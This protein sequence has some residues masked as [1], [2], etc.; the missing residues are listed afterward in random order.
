MTGP[1][2]ALYTRAGC[3]LCEA[4]IS[5]LRPY[6]ERTGAQLE[7]V[8]VDDDPALVRA[9]GADVPVLLVNDAELCRHRL[10]HDA[11]QAHLNESA[12]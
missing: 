2:L 9:Y 4:M 5:E 11:L 8:D 7:L 3:H 6:L 10:D 12:N 1:K